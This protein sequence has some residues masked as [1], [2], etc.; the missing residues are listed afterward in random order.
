MQLVS[1]GAG[2]HALSACPAETAKW[3]TWYSVTSGDVADYFGDGPA[4]GKI[5]G[6][7]A[8]RIARGT[9]TLDGV[10]YH[11]PINNGPNTCHSGPEGF[12][13]RN[14]TIMKFYFASSFE[15]CL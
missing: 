5:P 13:S 9:F 10:E 7:Y 15:I 6:R 2:V 12:H 1:V 3:P 14:W 4:A 11:L 8:N